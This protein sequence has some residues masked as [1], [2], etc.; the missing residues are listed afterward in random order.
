MSKLTLRVE[1]MQRT[2]SHFDLMAHGVSQ[3]IDEKS[4]E[5]AKKVQIRAK[6][7]APKKT[8]KL[9]KSIKNRKGKYGITH[10]VRPRSTVAHLQEYGTKKGIKSER[11]MQKAREQIVPGVQRDILSKVEQA[12]SR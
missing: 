12:V 7:L 6:E 4:K 5:G 3:V 10:I 11:F 2:L 1:G 8:G 9:R